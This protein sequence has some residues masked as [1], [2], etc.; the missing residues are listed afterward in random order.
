MVV[1]HFE[2]TKWVK[3]IT[4]KVGEILSIYPTQKL[5]KIL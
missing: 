2:I 5:E 1:S 4:D 3:V